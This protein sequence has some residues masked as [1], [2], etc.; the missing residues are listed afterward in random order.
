MPYPAS[1][2]PEGVD[3]T[4]IAGNQL[5]Q[6]INGEANE[7]VS[8][9]SGDI[10][11]VRK[12]LADSMMFKVPVD[13][14]Q[15][16]VTTDPLETR[17][18]NGQPY[19]APEATLANPIT[20]GASPVA[21]TDWLLAPQGYRNDYNLG[22]YQAGILIS[23]SQEY[24]VY[25]GKSYFALTPPYTTTSTTPDDDTNM[26]E[27][28]YT[29]IK[30][31]AEVFSNTNLLSNSNFL[32]PSPD[33]ITHLNAT[34]ESYVAGTQIFSGVYAGD[35]GCTVTLIDGRVNCTT[36]DYQFKVP[37]TGGLDRVP[38][39]AS[40]VSDYDGKP[41]TT[42]VSH[43]LVADE[44]VVTVT[45]AAGDVFSVKFEQGTVVTGHEVVTILSPT[46]GDDV[47]LL[48]NAIS[49][50]GYIDLGETGEYQ[51]SNR[52][53]VTIDR[54]LK[55]VT[56][57][58]VIK[59]TGPQ[60]ADTVIPLIY[61]TGTGKEKVETE[62]SIDGGLTSQN[63]FIPVGITVQ[64]VFMW[65]ESST[66]KNAAA[67]TNPISMK[68][69]ASTPKVFYENMIQTTLAS[70]FGGTYGY[71]FVAIDVEF[72]YISGGQW[73]T[74]DGPIH[75]HAHYISTFNDGTG[76]CGPFVIDGCNVEQI[77]YADDEIE[78]ITEFEYCTK[79]ISSESVIV[80]NNTVNGGQGHVL[81]TT[82][83]NGPSGVCVTDN[84][85]VRTGQRAYAVFPEGGSEVDQNPWGRLVSGAGN[86]YVLT[87][88]SASA[89][90]L[91]L[92]DTAIDKATYILEDTVN[93]TSAYSGEQVTLENPISLL[94]IESVLYN[95]E[96]IGT[97][98]N[99]DN[100]QVDCKY[101][102]PNL[103]NAPFAYVGPV[104]NKDIKIKFPTSSVEYFKG[105][106]DAGYEDV[107]YYDASFGRE[108][109]CIN[110][111]QPLWVDDNGNAVASISSG[112]PVN[113]PAQH[114]F[115]ETDLSRFVYW[116]KST[117]WTANVTYPDTGATTEILSV[118]PNFLGEGAEMYN[119][120]THLPYWYDKFNG[121][122]KTAAG[123]VLT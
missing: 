38:V 75:R 88:K 28:G 9:T 108:I 87:S 81:L 25:N 67:A 56:S 17:L 11:S 31:S 84:N 14:V 80:V 123:V 105:L 100:L 19:W 98:G 115:W 112:R 120:T 72:G 109:V 35:S 117:W 47:E 7:V 101:V 6:V 18:Y 12:A 110:G 54:N 59:Y 20:L 40:S 79:A 119:T 122:W 82:R 118:N 76:N 4:I 13:W 68:I 53:Q 93:I 96:R 71:G 91:Q 44:Y 45:P 104:S 42:G 21:T 106:P 46:G 34:P 55:L 16:E 29:T 114:K 43:A 39:F 15:G 113:V 107:R 10:P 30:S 83:P 52:V 99:V 77:R 62:L 78:P 102:N 74:K 24:V 89:M 85:N 51:I 49:K 70:S 3:L 90:R 50:G 103:D 116:T 33:A 8:T 2:Y 97:L 36:G 48:K 60:V 32:T 86:R 63:N 64:N 73:G 66:I 23:D 22:K 26:F 95:F 5:H 69:Y 58:A 111:T 92:I 121:E 41:K 61:I 37:N 94:D 65:V 27:G 1:S 57:G